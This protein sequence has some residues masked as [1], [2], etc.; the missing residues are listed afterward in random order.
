MPHRAFDRGPRPEDGRV[1]EQPAAHDDPRPDALTPAALLALQRT[2]GNRAA[3]TALADRAKL[4]RWRDFGAARGLPQYDYKIVNGNHPTAG[5]YHMKFHNVESLDAFD[6]IHVVFENKQPKAYFFYTDAGVLKPD[7]STTG[8]Q[9][10]DL[11]PIA[12]QLVND[13]LAT[14]KVVSDQ[15]IATKRQLKA[16]QEAKDKAVK[17]QHAKAVKEKSEQYEAKEAAAREASKASADDSLHIVNFLVDNKLGEG[18]KPAFVAY[19]E[20]KGPSRTYWKALADWYKLKRDTGWTVTLEEKRVAKAKKPTPEAVKSEHGL[21]AVAKVTITT[22]P[23]G[24]K[25]LYVTPVITFPNYTTYAASKIG[26][27]PGT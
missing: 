12:Q 22:K 4:S 18:E 16:E 10:P 25:F 19:L 5:P 27:K 11:E 17:D 23:S 6:E 14:S 7:K 24:P 2:A 3:T 15:E 1:P 20:G 9:H 21:P 8:L 13:Q 26:E